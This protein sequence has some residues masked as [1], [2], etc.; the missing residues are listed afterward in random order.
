[1]VNQYTKNKIRLLSILHD[2]YSSEKGFPPG[3]PPF[4]IDSTGKVILSP[5]LE[6]ELGKDVNRDLR[7]WALE[8]ISSL[9]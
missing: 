5:R 8:N 6:S 3:D 2:I 4:T 9:D 1:M 7:Q